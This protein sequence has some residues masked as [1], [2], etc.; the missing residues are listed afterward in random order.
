M[1]M[2]SKCELSCLHTELTG[3][4][5]SEKERVDNKKTRQNT[6]NL[7][8]STIKAG[9]DEE[10]LRHCFRVVSPEREYLLQ[11]S[12][13]GRECVKY[14]HCALIVAEPSIVADHVHKCV[15]HSQ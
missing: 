11:A 4:F 8:T 6:V 5:S 15:C 13:V 9:A 1:L 2:L 12:A 10:G 3:N 7:L 14:T